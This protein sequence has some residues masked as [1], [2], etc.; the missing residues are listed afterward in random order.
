[1]SRSAPAV[2]VIAAAQLDAE[3]LGHRDLHMIDVAAIPHRL[4]NSVRKAKRQNVLN[5]FFSEIMVDAEDLLFLEHFAESS[6]FSATAEARSWPNGFSMT[7]R[8]H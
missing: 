8:F 1:M 6:R 4:E 7:T 5:G 3:F 2:I